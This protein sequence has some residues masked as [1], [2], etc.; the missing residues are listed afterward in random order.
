[1]T[2]AA[3]KTNQA[4]G[5]R[6]S[7]RRTLATRED[8]DHKAGRRRRGSFS[9]WATRGFGQSRPPGSGIEVAETTRRPGSASWT[10]SLRIAADLRK[11]L[12]VSGGN[13]VRLWVFSFGLVHSGTRRHL[14]RGRSGL[15]TKAI[16][17]LAR[18]H[19]IAGTHRS[20]PASPLTERRRVDSVNTLS[21]LTQSECV[22]LKV[23]PTNAANT[24]SG[25]QRKNRAFDA[26][27]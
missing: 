24:H 12:M 8:P 23:K 15:P 10:V 9:A 11:G 3:D 7:R 25:D 19:E 20:T 21:Q 13:R 22:D 5:G 17:S 2:A 14:P 6:T 16:R 26:T 1:M 27:L 4:D 18:S